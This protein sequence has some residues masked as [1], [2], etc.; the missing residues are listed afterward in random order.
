MSAKPRST[1]QEQIQ[2]SA[3]MRAEGATWA[4]VAVEFSRRYRVNARVALRL[5]HGWSQPEAAGHWNARWPDDP[6]TF[7]NFSIWELW[8]GPTGHPPSVPNLDRLAQ[9]YECHVADVLRDLPDYG[10]SAAGD[11]LAEPDGGILRPADV[12]RLL[13]DLYGQVSAGSSSLSLPGRCEVALLYRLREIDFY[14]LAKVIIVWAHQ[15]NSLSRRAVLSK[16]SAAFTLAAA[17][18][19][20]LDLADR[21]E[22]DRVAG[23]LNEPSRLDKATLSYVEGTLPTYRRQ[24]NALGPQATLPVVLAQRQ[25]LARLVAAAPDHLRL[26]VLAVHAELSQIAGWQ[27]Y[28][29]GDYRAA[30]HYYE[31]AYTA[32]HEGHDLELVSKVLANMSR[33]ALWQDRPKTGIAYAL[34]AQEWASKSGSRYARGTAAKL[35]APIYAA[36]GQEESCLAALDIMQAIASSRGDGAPAPS[37]AWTVDE[38]FYWSTKGEC[39]RRLGRYDEALAAAETALSLMDPTDRLNYLHTVADQAEAHLR[40]ADP[41]PASQVLGEVLILAEGYRSFP[42]EQ[43][44]VRMRTDLNQW[45]RTKAVRELDEKLAHYRRSIGSP[46]TTTL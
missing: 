36:D 25:E 40:Q 46:P 41:T 28:N 10:A 33:L 37:W 20:L 6:K 29:L 19:L 12:Q 9:L 17:S 30:Q 13:L 22:L 2:I 21:D 16:L 11:G 14:E 5:A 31:Q 34:A 8:P 32:A 43:R 3:A 15:L 18:P 26:R 45:Q 7:K 39:A 38:S 35:A 4:D 1:K 42:L 24:G 44:I 23:V 27:F